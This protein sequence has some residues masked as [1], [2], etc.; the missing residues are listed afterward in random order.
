MTR[1]QTIDRPTRGSPTMSTYRTHVDLAVPLT[2]DDTPERLR[3]QLSTAVEKDR[4]TETRLQDSRKTLYQAVRDAHAVDPATKPLLAASGIKSSKTI[5]QALQKTAPTPGLDLD[6]EGRFKALEIAGEKWK[7]AK[8]EHDQA[9]E[10]RNEAVVRAYAGGLDT[11]EIGE[12]LGGYT[13]QRVNQILRG[14][15]AKRKLPAAG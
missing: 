13:T 8:I 10:D 14:V 2:N 1:L 7:K 15:E 12:L 4:E 9:R 6:K 5:H 11:T 3:K